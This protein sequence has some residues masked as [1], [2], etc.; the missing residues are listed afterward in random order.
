MKQEIKFE[1]VYDGEWIEPTPQMG[2]KIKCCDCEL[3]HTINFRVKKG[4]VQFQVFKEEKDNR[5]PLGIKELAKNYALNL[6]GKPSPDFK[7]EFDHFVFHLAKFHESLPPT[8]DESPSPQSSTGVDEK[9]AKYA[10]E[11]SDGPGYAGYDERYYG[12]KAGVASTE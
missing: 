3:I 7:P 4:K 2:H 9:A 10:R 6:Y 11:N 8:P 12:F 1:Q 5:P